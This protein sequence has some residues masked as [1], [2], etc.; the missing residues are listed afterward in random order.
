[1]AASASWFEVNPRSSQTF[2][3]SSVS[4]RSQQPA[5]LGFTNVPSASLAQPIAPP[6]R[7][8]RNGQNMN[9]TVSPG[10]NVL[11]VMPRSIS[12]VG[13]DAS[14]LKSVTSPFSSTLT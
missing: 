4:S 13:D 2:Q 8:S 3:R 12:V 9:V 5:S 14:R 10:S 1:S 11:P 7:P 6:G